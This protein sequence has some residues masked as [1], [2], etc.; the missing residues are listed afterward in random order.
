MTQRLFIFNL[1]IVY[2]WF[3]WFYSQHTAHSILSLGATRS[4]ARNIFRV[5]LV[6]WTA[7]TAGP[8]FTPAVSEAVVTPNI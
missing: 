1:F 3:Y 2:S 5:S 7:G 8:V 6:D 4:L